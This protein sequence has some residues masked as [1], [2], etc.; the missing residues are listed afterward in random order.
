MEDKFLKSTIK[1]ILRTT[2]PNERPKNVILKSRSLT[3]F[4]LFD[5]RCKCIRNKIKTADTGKPNINIS[6]F[7]FNVILII[8][9]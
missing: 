7:S 2:E 6:F 5:Y 9:N 1:L 4:T 3:Y 8:N